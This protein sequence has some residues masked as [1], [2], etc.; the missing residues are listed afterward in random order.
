[1]KS[2]IN[3]FFKNKWVKYIFIILIIII[4]LY[5]LSLCAEKRVEKF[6]SFLNTDNSKYWNKDKR[7]DFINLSSLG[8]DLGLTD[9]P[10]V[11]KFNSMKTSD[12]KTTMRD[13]SDFNGSDNKD[14]LKQIMPVD[15]LNKN[16]VLQ[17]NPDVKNKVL[18]DAIQK[19]VEKQS[20]SLEGQRGGVK[21]YP[22]TI[23]TDNTK[24]LMQNY[25]EN[26]TFKNNK[27]NHQNHQ[28]HQQNQPKIQQRNL[29]DKF[30]NQSSSIQ[31]PSHNMGFG[32][33]N[34]FNDSCPSDYTEMGSIGIQGLPSG[35][36][37][38]CG[39]VSA[40]KPAVFVAELSNG[41]ISNVVIVDGGSGYNPTKNYNLSVIGGG[42]GSGAELKAIIGDDGLIKS[43]NIVKGGSGFKET[44]KIVIDNST[45]TG[46]CNFCC[47]N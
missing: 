4:P 2:N 33:C 20:N 12:V 15:Q 17:D 13:S 43:I 32:K 42:G 10:E 11:K 34:F 27:K 18:N 7:E 14:L 19:Q 29:K 21:E 35:M 46:K 23:Y 40:S 36:T 6:T 28:N 45:N 26:D 41:S 25:I 8:L 1:M 30:E 37:L 38:T 16:K 44:P 5:L 47:K 39:N 3:N 22:S 31:Q 9:N 24:Q